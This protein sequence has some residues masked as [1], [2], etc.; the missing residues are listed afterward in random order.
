MKKSTPILL[1]IIAILFVAVLY[2]LYLNINKTPIVSTPIPTPIIKLVPTSISE[3]TIVSKAN[4][5][6]YNNTALGF[7]LTFPESWKNKYSAVERSNSVQF[8][9]KGTSEKSSIF[10][11][12]VMSEV[13]WL[14]AQSMPHGEL[15]AQVENTKEVYIKN[16]ALENPF[17]DITLVEKFSLMIGDVNSILSTFK[18]IYKNEET[19]LDVAKKYLDS[20]ISGNW[21]VVKEINED[22]NFDENIA[23][24]YNITN[25]KIISSKVDTKDQNYFHAYVDLT[26][27]D[28]QVHKISPGGTQ[29]EVLM[30][31]DMSG[32][33]KALTWYFFQ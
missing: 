20:Y 16:I 31:K 9:M 33:W 4:L 23:K 24:S 1:T 6:T 14:K 18:F 2:L 25:Y 21:S 29:I 12:S 10:T 28:G 22:T 11:I 3:P 17:T 5:D 26:T 30:H 19:A 7:S 32:K 27:S 15:I 13:D 8:I